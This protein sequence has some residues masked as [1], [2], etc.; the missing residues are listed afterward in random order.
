MTC[1][2]EPLDQILFAALDELRMTEFP[3][4]M[5]NGPLAVIEGVDGLGKTVTVI[6]TELLGQ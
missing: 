6:G 4:Q 5:V 3:W 2:L 1:A